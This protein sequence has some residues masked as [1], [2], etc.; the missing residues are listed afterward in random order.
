MW[1]GATNA[2]TLGALE[3]LPGALGG[4][5]GAAL[6]AMVLLLSCLLLLSTQRD[7]WHRLPGPPPAS[8]LL[9]HLPQVRQPE[10]CA[11]SCAPAAEAAA[12]LL[13]PRRVPPPPPP[14]AS[15]EVGYRTALPSA[16]AQLNV[17]TVHRFFHDSAQRYGQRGMYALRMLHL[18]I[19]VLC[20][21]EL[22]QAVVARGRSQ[23]KAHAI[24]DGVSE[25]FSAQGHR[26]FFTTQDVEEWRM[27]RRCA[28][29]G[30][31]APTACCLRAAPPQCPTPTLLPPV[32]R[33]AKPPRPPSALTTFARRSRCCAT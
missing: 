22:V 21:P 23:P 8:W 26:N 1:P 31:R 32:C 5:H 25:L 18:K 27:V 15:T 13:P 10:L 6:A 20:A 28:H 3:A 19:V 29:L 4:V 17:P 33:Y 14:P 24:Y 12:V 2:T 9:G 30:G 16:P 7:D 11:E